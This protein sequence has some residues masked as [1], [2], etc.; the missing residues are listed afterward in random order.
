M[1]PNR[2]TEARVIAAFAAVALF[3]FGED[4]LAAESAQIRM[5]LVPLG[6]FFIGQSDR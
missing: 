1:T 5:P 6:R 3:N 4:A 2:A